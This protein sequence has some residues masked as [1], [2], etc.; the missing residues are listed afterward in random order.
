MLVCDRC[1]KK[2]T[3]QEKEGADITLTIYSAEAAYIG[4]CLDLC[5]DCRRLYVD[6]KDKMQSYFMVNE[7]PMKLLNDEVYWDRAGKYK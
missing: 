4:H 3:Y 1:G 6:Y 2:L 7:D 5:K